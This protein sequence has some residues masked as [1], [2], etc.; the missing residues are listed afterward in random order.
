MNLLNSN[1][2]P[3][4]REFEGWIISNI[5]RYFETRGIKYYI[6]ALM[7]EE[8]K[9]IGADE[10]LYFSD[11]FKI[12]GLQFK[13][14]YINKNKTSWESLYWN[15]NNPPNQFL[16]VVTTPNLYYCLPAFTNRD[17]RKEALSHCY[18]WKPNENQKKGNFYFKKEKN[19]IENSI[20]WEKFIEEVFQDK[21]GKKF[22]NQIELNRKMKINDFL[23]YID[24]KKTT[25]MPPILFSTTYNEDKQ[26]DSV[27][28][29]IAIEN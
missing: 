28:Y 15:L 19:S 20:N 4:E 2:I 22:N 24:E 7:Q 8:E 17:F 21:I 5:E 11:S 6:R 9:E 27:L 14:P 25:T 26:Q 10:F 13:R 3:L 12:F 16:K 29:L 18:F 1:I 23:G